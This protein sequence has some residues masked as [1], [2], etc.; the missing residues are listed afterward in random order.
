MARMIEL[1]IEDAKALAVMHDDLTPK[2]C[3]AIYKRLPMEG[4][5]LSAKWACREI[6]LHLTGYMYL[7]LEPEG[8]RRRDIAP[9][10]IFYFLRGPGLLGAQNEYGPE[11]KYKL[12]EFAI[13]Y[14]LTTGSPEDP[15][16]LM[17]QEYCKF[18]PEIPRTTI[19]WAHLQRPIPRDFYLSCES[20][21]HGRK[22]LAI[23]RHVE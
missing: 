12:C 6:M 17:D 22:K 7:E 14:G 5:A 19:F 20:V 1:E 8:P 15:G 2:A 16:R 10:D 18:K 9:G 3:D 11:F 21:R 13:Y 23:G 4:M